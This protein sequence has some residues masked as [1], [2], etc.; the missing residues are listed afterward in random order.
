MFD[1]SLINR[2][3]AI[4][5]KSQLFDVEYYLNTYLDVKEAGIDPVRHYIKHG[6]RE[7]RNPS[8]DFN[9]REYIKS[10][11][12]LF[13]M[14]SNPLVHYIMRKYP[15]VYAQVLGLD[16][17]LKSKSKVI[18]EKEKDLIKIIRDGAFF[19][20]NFYL[21]QLD[22]EGDRS[23]PDLLTHFYEEG[24][25]A[26]K[27]PVQW[28]DIQTYISNRNDVLESGFNPYLHFLEY[29]YQENREFSPLIELSEAKSLLANSKNKWVY[30]ESL[31]KYIKT[32]V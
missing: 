14:K 30:F 26:Y 7:A 12:E 15:E 16:E 2:W 19:D 18:L 27:S 10:N 6:V 20:T 4:I 23:L 29:G 32:Q 3:I 1:E 31:N 28:F 11:P 5:N 17:T 22:F 25:K 21:S 9:T 13:K 24:S 8:K